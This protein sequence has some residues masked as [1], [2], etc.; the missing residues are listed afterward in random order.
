VFIS[1]ENVLQWNRR[2]LKKRGALHERMASLRRN[3]LMR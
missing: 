2:G 3:G 1:G